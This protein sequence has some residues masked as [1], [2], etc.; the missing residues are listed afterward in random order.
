MYL[1]INQVFLSCLF[2]Q[3]YSC[4]YHCFTLSCIHIVADSLVY[5]SIVLFMNC[6][7]IFHV[8]VGY[9][10]IYLFVHVLFL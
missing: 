5:I 2:I 3:F 4:I 9:L 10:L 1:L 7:S 8:S 6:V